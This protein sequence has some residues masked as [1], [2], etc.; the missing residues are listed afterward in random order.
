MSDRLNI[1]KDINLNKVRSA[2]KKLGVA[3][4]PQLAEDTGLSVV[5]I[6]SLV[7]T[8][9]ASGEILPHKTIPSDGGRPA[10]SFRYNS[11]YRLALMIYMHELHGQDQ[12]YYCVVNLKGEV[13]EREQQSL[14]QVTV[15]SFDLNIERMLQK[16]PQIKA[17]CFGI[18]GVEVD[19]KLMII[20]Y[21]GLRDQSLSGHIMERFQ[22]PV[23]IEN[24]INAAI[25]GYCHINEI[26]KEQ[27]VIGIYYPDKYPPGAGIYM[28]GDIYKGRDGLAGEI[29]Y[30]PLGIVWEEFDYNPQE[31][32]ALIIKTLRAF[33]CMYNPDRIILYGESL[34]PDL[35]NKV[36]DS[37]LTP[38]E[39]LMLAEIVLSADLN[40]DFEAGIKQLAVRMIDTVTD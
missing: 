6:N 32:E 30:L 33:S 37:C 16:F 39:E 20:D 38:V 4:K 10:A 18:P 28:K 24:D 15:S 22:L 27:C 31:V 14:S 17:I 5:T 2:I 29:K 3:T 25:L 34:P 35:I 11:E 40:H 23:M 12:A 13:L 1:I 7:N 36:R 8:L 21:A 9:I 19:H 26:P